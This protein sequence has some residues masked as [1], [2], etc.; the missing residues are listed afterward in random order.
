MDFGFLL[1]KTNGQKM[2]HT[3]LRA[4]KEPLDLTFLDV[5]G[6]ISYFIMW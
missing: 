5:N 3:D 1:T 4:E 6:R 2:P